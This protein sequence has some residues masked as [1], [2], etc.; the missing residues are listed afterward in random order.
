MIHIVAIAACVVVVIILAIVVLDFILNRK[1]IKR[2]SKA[3]A[4]PIWP[5]H[6]EPL[7]THSAWRKPLSFEARKACPHCGH[8]DLHQISKPNHDAKYA[9][10][11][12]NS[13]LPKVIHF[14]NRRRR[15][16]G[17]NPKAAIIRNCAN[18]NHMWG[19]I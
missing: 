3:L 6:Y 13:D 14:A 7:E 2:Y 15:T 10:Q 8:F 16:L 5:E 9:N 4:V 17:D 18:C 12:D 1:E 19:E 11:Y